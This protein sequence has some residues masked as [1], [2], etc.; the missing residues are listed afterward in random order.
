MLSRPGFMA[1]ALLVALGFAAPVAAQVVDVPNALVFYFD[2]AATQRSWYGTGPVT[3]YL[4]AGPLDIAGEP[5][6]LLSSWA[7]PNVDIWPH[8]NVANPTLTMRGDAAPAVLD[9]DAMQ[10]G[11]VVTLATPLPL[12]GRTVVAELTMDV[13]SDTPTRLIAWA[14]SFAA[15]GRTGWFTTLTHG[16]DGPMDFTGNT[17]NI[18][19]ASPVGNGN[20][21]ASWG[22]VKALF[23]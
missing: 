9:L 6:R 8:D 19:D 1:S 15:D 20:A 7:S 18:N 10:M 22:R 11:F 23:R 5:C 2:E 13:V 17:A 21:N 12:D 16:P 14:D 4:V 3:A